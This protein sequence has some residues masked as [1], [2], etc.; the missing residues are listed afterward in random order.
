M[1]FALFDLDGTLTSAHI[2]GGLMAYF[3]TRRRKRL[4]HALYLAV[5]YP[6]YGLRKAGLIG[7]YPFRYRWSSNLGWYLRGESETDAAAIG[8]WVAK[9]YLEGT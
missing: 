2:W 9:T 5:H 4:T 6:L 7:E 1:P 3:S 8:D